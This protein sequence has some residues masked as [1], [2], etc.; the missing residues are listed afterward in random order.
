MDAET[1]KNAERWTIR[2]VL[3]ASAD[4]L[5][6]QGSPTA[7]LD[8]EVLLAHAL[9]TDR[10]GLYV[11][12]EQPLLESELAPYR[13][14]LRRRAAREPVAYLT[15][16]KEF[17]GLSFKVARGVL[18]P[19]P[20]TEILV[21]AVLAN[22]QECT[23]GVFLEVGVGSGAIALSV[24]KKRPRLQAVGVD[25][26]GAALEVSRE[27]AA[28][29]GLSDR[30]ELRRGDLFGAVKDGEKFDL[31]LSNPPYIRSSGISELEPEI[32]DYEP[33]EALDG[34]ADGFS[35]IRVLIG[36]AGKYLRGGG[37]LAI[38]LGEDQSEE[39]FALAEK[40][41]VWENIEIRQDL[42]GLDRVLLARRKSQVEA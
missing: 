20:D 39:A 17:F 32:R 4:Y 14:L 35:V 23:A 19:R 26:S 16:R 38:E 40:A 42:A 18:I 8:A 15:G 2:R 7:R 31:L 5:E 1:A 29:L 11:N 41:G 33:R 28:A 12:L 25:V 13:E 3:Q 37:L 30:I 22:T 21:E 10:V 24:L 36:E 6:R 34:G 27:N 9:S